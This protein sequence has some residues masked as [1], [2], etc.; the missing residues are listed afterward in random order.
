MTAMA[1]ALSVALLHFVWQGLVVAFGLWVALFILRKR[2][3]NT[4]YLTS[5]AALAVLAVLP[6]I[7]AYLAYSGPLTGHPP[8]SLVRAIPRIAGAVTASSV[9]SPSAWLPSLE[10]W[11]LPAW[12]L[13]VL[14]FS[15]RLV[16]ATKQVSALRRGAQ[17]PEAPM[18]AII[19]GLA[20]RMRLARPVRVLISSIPDGPSVVGWIR[21]VVL[22]PAATI[23]GLTPQ[24]LEAVLAHELAHIRR[25]DYLVNMLQILVET[26]LF[27]HPAVW[28]TSAQI[29]HEREMCCD[30]LAVVAC[31]DALCYARALTRLERLRVMRPR[32][33][34]GGTDGPL[35][36]RIRRLIGDQ[37]Q[38]YGPS[39]LPGILALS[40]GLACLALNMQWA[41]GQQQEARTPEPVALES[42]ALDDPGIRVDLGGAAVI[43]RAPVEYPDV[44]LQ[45]GVQGTVVVEVT[46]DASG[47]VSDARVLSGPA[48]L[49]KAALESV[50]QWHFTHDAAGSTHQV[51]IAF[52]TP[53]ANSA[54]ESSVEP[55]SHER[56]QQFEQ[57][58][59]AQVRA[60]KLAREAQAEALEKELRILQN[61]RTELR[62]QTDPAQAEAVRSEIAA[63]AKRLA[64]ADRALADAQDPLRAEQAELLAGKLRILQ[65]QLAEREQTD[66]AEADAVRSEIA[67]ME[68]QLA[69]AD[70]ALAQAQGPLRAGQS[71]LLAGKLRLLQK[72]LAERAQTDPAQAE[73]VRDQMAALEKRLLDAQMALESAQAASRLAQSGVLERELRLLQKQQ[74]KRALTDTAQAEAMNSQIVAL[75]KNLADARSVLGRA[76]EGDALSGFMA[77]RKLKSIA[78]LGLT[79]QLRSELLSQLP[80]HVGDTLSEDSFARIEAAVKQFDEHLDLSLYTGTDGEVELRIAAPN[81][82]SGEF[83]K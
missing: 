5:C 52:Q 46:L 1:Q 58:L 56:K 73:A 7:T 42:A 10:R 49:R 43:H 37:G 20:S 65:K 72:Q 2:S 18:L 26:L 64:E 75:K 68:K 50:L 30:D 76:G 13:G 12:A 53:P 34:L 15:L 8:G 78:I 29:R 36:Y 33:A 11:A 3:A 79:E 38:E 71:E 61:Q 24:Q 48:D 23:L 45:A 63:M 14:L 59:E 17:P 81:S 47:M 51:G 60:A 22:L 67:A 83:R 74:A 28:W 32:L 77:G 39:K 4:R 19:A 9:P 25:Y 16:W 27:Y 21:P 41:R 66:P 57:A 80:V 44:A 69:E 62:E 31:G 70:R 54:A 40:L 6:V 55:A 82:G 35:F